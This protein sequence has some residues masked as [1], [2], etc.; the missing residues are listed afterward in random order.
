MSTHGGKR[1]GSGPKSPVS[2]YGETT[3]VIRVPTSIKADVLVYLEAF[4]INAKAK[5]NNKVL[6]NTQARD[7][8]KVADNPLE[9]PLPIYSGKVS[10][11]QSRFPSPA[12]DYEQEE[13]DLNK[14][15]INNPPA[16]F[17]YR[18]GSTQDSMID[19]GIQ[20]NCLL[21]VDRSIAPKSSHIIIAEVDGESMVKRLYKRRGIVELRSENK[22]K[23]YAPIVFQEGQELIVSGVVTFNVNTL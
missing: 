13:L 17:L 10:A 19:A 18:V 16:T 14:H 2:P 7:Y 21:I 9:L 6:L 12:Q 3:S 23:N 22:V 1:L 15:L 11:G 20:P 8:I 4:K 5:A